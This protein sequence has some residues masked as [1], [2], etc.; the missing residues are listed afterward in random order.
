M[1]YEHLG[2]GSLTLAL[3]ACSGAHSVA[4]PPVV[5]RT[6][7]TN[8]VSEPWLVI[9]APPARGFDSSLAVR[10][11]AHGDDGAWDLLLNDAVRIELA[12][13]GALRVAAHDVAISG[14]GTG[15]TNGSEWFF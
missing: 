14:I 7:A 12:R 3:I 9:P 4:S 15:A 5:P 2:I 10:A 6:T 8:I 11:L 13:D 1:R